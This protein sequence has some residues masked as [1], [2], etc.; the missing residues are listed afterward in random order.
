LC[1]NKYPPVLPEDDAIF[2]SQLA[3]QELL[4]QHGYLQYEIS[5]YAQ[6]DKQC[7]HNLNYWSFGDYLGIGAGAHGKITQNTPHNIVKASL[8]GNGYCAYRFLC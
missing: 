6:A 5:A 7:S 2:N 1:V 8:L 4:A 3:C